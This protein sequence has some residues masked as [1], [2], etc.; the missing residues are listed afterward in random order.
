VEGAGAARTSFVAI[1][2]IQLMKMLSVALTCNPQFWEKG[3]DYKNGQYNHVNASTPA[4]CC[5]ECAEY[6][7]FAPKKCTFWTFGGSTCWL[8]SNN[9]GARQEKGDVVSGSVNNV[10]LPTPAVPTPKPPT[11]PP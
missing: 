2:G 10:P 11:P 3:L 1:S 5:L 6:T 7:G 9:Q 4:E 8:K